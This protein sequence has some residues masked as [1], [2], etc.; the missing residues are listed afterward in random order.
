M[1][2]INLSW[3]EMTGELRQQRRPC[4][5]LRLQRKPGAGM[6]EGERREVRLLEERA[7]RTERLR[8]T[9]LIPPSGSLAFGTQKSGQIWVSNLPLLFA[10]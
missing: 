10:V 6:G 9:P 4:L 7:W 5:G 1:R 8:G 2:S 3:A